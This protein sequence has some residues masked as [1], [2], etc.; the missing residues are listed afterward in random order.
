MPWSTRAFFGVV[1]FAVLLPFLDMRGVW[2]ELVW[3]SL[4]VFAVGPVR[5]WDF[6]RRRSAPHHRACDAATIATTTPSAR[7]HAPAHT[8]TYS[9]STHSHVPT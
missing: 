1:W 7:P 6:C 3:L 4:F 9:Y 2:D 8:Q 5:F